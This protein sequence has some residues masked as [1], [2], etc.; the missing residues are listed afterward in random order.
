MAHGDAVTEPLI[1]P[2]PQLHTL[3]DLKAAI[4]RDHLA[5]GIN[6]KVEIDVWEPDA[7]K[8]G[9]PLITIELGDGV[10]GEPS[11]HYQ[12]GAWWPVNPTCAQTFGLVTTFDPAS[13]I[14]AALSGEPDAGATI[15]VLFVAGGVTG[16]ASVIAYAVSV[17]SGATYQDARALND[18]TTILVHGTTVDLGTG[19]TATAGD[20]IVWTQRRATSDLARPMLDDAQTYTLSIHAPAPSGVADANR[21]VSAQDATDQLKRLTM[22]AIR[23]QLAGPFRVAARVRWPK[24]F[25]E[26]PAFVHGSVCVVDLVLASPILDD[27]AGAG[28]ALQLEMDG[29]VDFGGGEVTV[30][31]ALET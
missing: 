14:T 1:I 2:T 13:T 27:F 25:P 17:D 6:A 22:G 26:W 31:T 10:I 28:Q 15:S 8:R 20:T 9:M 23:R 7:I 12:P 16:S 4:D 5:H 30:V 21:A 24:R 18:A 11:K 29:T 19:K 3:R